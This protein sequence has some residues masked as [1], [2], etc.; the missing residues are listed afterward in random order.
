MVSY[1]LLAPSANILHLTRCIDPPVN[2]NTSFSVLA[3]ALWTPVPSALCGAS[4][5]RWRVSYHR[6]ITHL[7]PSRDGPLGEG[8][9]RLGG[10]F[11]RLPRC[12]GLALAGAPGSVLMLWP[13]HRVGSGPV[14]PV[15]VRVGVAR[16][17]RRPFRSVRCLR[18]SPPG[19][20]LQATAFCRC[21]ASAGTGRGTREHSLEPLCP[22]GRDRSASGPW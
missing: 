8:R 13:C 1:R 16:V 11:L 21:E 14:V 9:F 20:S 4:T 2:N 5:E 22:A 10:G 6:V 12:P 7:Y 15:S 17:R 19:P 3:T 18:F